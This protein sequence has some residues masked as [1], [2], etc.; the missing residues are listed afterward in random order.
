VGEVESFSCAG[1]E[2]LKSALNA[3]NPRWSLLLAG[4]GDIRV[5]FIQSFRVQ[6]GAIAI[7]VSRNNKSRCKPGS[8]F[9]RNGEAF[10]GKVDSGM[11][12]S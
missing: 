6:N 11:K 1:Q 3:K 8:A 12:R 7:D 2:N 4:G 10:E 5:P 9:L